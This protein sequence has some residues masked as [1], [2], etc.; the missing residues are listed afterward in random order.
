ME[1]KEL[2]KTLIER[3]WEISE[4]KELLK[5]QILEMITLFDIKALSKKLHGKMIWIYL[6]ISIS[7]KVILWLVCALMMENIRLITS[8]LK[9]HKQMFSYIQNQQQLYQQENFCISFTV[10]EAIISTTLL[11]LII[12]SSKTIVKI[13]MNSNTKT[14]HLFIY[15]QDESRKQLLTTGIN[16]S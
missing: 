5:D 7:I 14:M 2:S 10:K 16:I 6:Q 1:R 4:L 15:W 8:L 13:Y 9:F 12:Y 11:K 3:R